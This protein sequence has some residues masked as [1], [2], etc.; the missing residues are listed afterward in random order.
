MFRTAVI[1]AL[2]AALGVAGWWLVVGHPDPEPGLIVE[3]PDRVLTD[4]PAGRERKHP[5]E[6]RVVNRTR[7]T[8]RVVGAD[9]G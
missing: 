7:R 5:V 1:G 6:Y 3:D 8:L 4:V 9:Y 2:A